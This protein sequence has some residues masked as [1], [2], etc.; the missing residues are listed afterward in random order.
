MN[1]VAFYALRSKVCYF[2]PPKVELYPRLALCEVLY[3]DTNHGHGHVFMGETHASD[4]TYSR[5]EDCPE[6]RFEYLRYAL[7]CIKMAQDR[8]E[9]CLQAVVGGED[10]GTVK[11]RKRIDT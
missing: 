8:L 4:C 3:T 7:C 2:Y 10:P 9:E 11:G 5:F 6:R 1:S